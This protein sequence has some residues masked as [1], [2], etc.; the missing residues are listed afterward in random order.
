[1]RASESTLGVQAIRAKQKAAEKSAQLAEKQATDLL[2][3]A[4]KAKS[5]ADAAAAAAAVH[6]QTLK[7]KKA[8]AAAEEIVAELRAGMREG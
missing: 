2:L 4:Q 7:E 1:M 5:E 8:K 3:R 6:E